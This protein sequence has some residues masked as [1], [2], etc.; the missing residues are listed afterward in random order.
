MQ[1]S[2]VAL[3]Y[4]VAGEIGL[5]L[6]LV[7]HSV[8]PLWPPTGVAIVALLALGSRTWPAVTI[9]AV[10]INVPL[11]PTV[12]AALLIAVGNTVAPLA[13]V[14]LLEAVHFH[15][16]LARVR[17]AAALVLLGALAAMAISATVGTLALW[18]SGAIPGH[19]FAGAWSVWWT[20]DAMG[21]LIVAPFL[22]S[23]AH[24]TEHRKQHPSWEVIAA[25]GALFVVCGIVMAADLP[26]WFVIV[27]VLG[28]IAWRFG[29]RGAAGAD[30]VVSVI[31]TIVAARE[32]GVFEGM[33]LVERMVTLQSFNATV[34]FTSLLLA[35]AVSQRADIAA[36]Q[37]DAV[38]TLQRSLLPERLC[39]VPG[40]ELAARYIP[41]NDQVELGGDWYD[42]ISLNDGRYGVVIG[43]VAGHGILAAAIMGK[44]R[45]ALRAF[46]SD[47]SSPGTALERLN[48]LLGDLQEGA[49]ATVWYGQYDPSSHLLVFTNAGHVP[50]LVVDAH[51]G[52][53]LEDVHGPPVGVLDRMHF[54]ESY[55]ALEP[56]TTLF[57]YT[58]G[59]VER[60]RS[61]LDDG[62]ARLRASVPSNEADLEQTCDAIVHAVAAGSS[63][64]DIAMLAVR[65]R[66]DRRD[67]HI[68]RR[69][70]AASVPETR[71]LVQAWLAENGIDGSEAF[72]VLLATTEAC[73]N[74]VTHAYGLIPGV[75][76]VTGCLTPSHVHIV[77][78]DGGV[79]RSETRARGGGR[80]L[81]IMRSFMDHVEV[82]TTPRTEIRMERRVSGAR[83]E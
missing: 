51:G 30:L 32:L 17:D 76:E 42:V 79:W 65:V 44:I 24:H 75:M 60:R 61:G 19:H 13:A 15:I 34:V 37:R 81:A 58:D 69:A 50:P 80:G 49:T 48:A 33:A 5:R 83:C 9:A 68:V 29:Q 2:I 38:E 25:A 62:L 14:A 27:P 47:G 82:V 39:E 35:A 54:G 3:T 55:Y 72:D 78:S 7:G 74:V 23:L 8:T 53:Y 56:G 1:V 52:Q 64:D 46:A 6:S 31:A 45:T 26:L 10:A 20:G 43:D 12:S 63:D 4:Y 59:L 66:A 21:V 18:W 40:L 67:L 57:L 22:W 36:V 77:V 28:V 41:A 73:G 11:G 71:H 70:T 16:D